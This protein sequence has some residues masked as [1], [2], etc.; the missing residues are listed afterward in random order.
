[1]S[2]EL[3]KGDW[4]IQLLHSKPKIHLAKKLTV[5]KRA[6]L[7]YSSLVGEYPYNVVSAVQGPESFG[8]GMEYPTITVISPTK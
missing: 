2:I 4:R 1:M 6:V 5:F 3:G 7:H 8:G